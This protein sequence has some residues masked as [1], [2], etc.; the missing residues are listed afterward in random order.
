MNTMKTHNAQKNE[1]YHNP[2]NPPYYNVLAWVMLGFIYAYRLVLSPYMGKQCKFQPTCSQY[3]LDCIRTHGA[4]KGGMLTLWRVVRCN[5]WVEG[6]YEPIPPIKEP[7][8][9]E[10]PKKGPHKKEH[11]V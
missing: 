3:G 10:P 4:I 9:K 1:P 5:P 11:N 7:P 8:T 6:G 2:K